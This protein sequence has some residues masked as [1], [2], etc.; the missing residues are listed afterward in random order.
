MKYSAVTPIVLP[1]RKWPNRTITHSP[2]WCSVDLRDGNQA[3][4]NP[5]G[6][7][8]KLQLFKLLV[9]IG[10]KEIEIGFPA[11]SDT[12][13]N[14]CRLLIDEDHIPDDVTVQVLT[15]ARPELITRTFDALKGAKSSIV[16]FYNST[17]PAQRKIVFNAT[18]TEVC[19][20]AKQAARLIKA[21]SQSN[22]QTKWVYQYSPES[23]SLTEL[24]FAKRIC[25]EVIDIL[26]KDIII[27]LPATV[28]STTPNIYADQ[29]EWMVDQLDVRT[30]SLH[31]HN[32]RGCGVAAT[33]LGILA[34]ASRVEGTLFGNGERTGNADI[35]T[36]ALNLF[37]Q[38][39][40]P[41]LDFSN[42]PKIADTYT[43]LTGMS[44]H[45]RHP[46][47]G[48]LVF[49]AFS[50]SHQDAIAKGMAAQDPNGKWE[51]PYLPIDPKDIGIGYEPIVR[52]NSQSG[53]GGAK[54]VLESQLGINLPRV[55]SVDV[56][57]MTKTLSDR[58]QREIT[59]DE[60]MAGF[61]SEF[62][63]PD[64]SIQIVESQTNAKTNVELSIKLSIDGTESEHK[65]SGNGPI[66]A[67]CKILSDITKQNI[68]VDGYQE[69]SMGE[70]AN[71]KAFA[72]VYRLGKCG[73]GIDTNSEQ[74]ALKAVIALTNRT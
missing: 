74:A 16:H 60:L 30:I 12:E 13:Y 14:F 24:P 19:D 29:I 34:G 50:G 58:L 1:Q 26:G 49:T 59:Q 55:L 51:V 53:K 15:Q 6:I 40:A 63:Q 25:Q 4:P 71:A 22:P 33:E 39:V 61:Y 56:G 65:A 3:L 8:Q 10:F 52:I 47:A 69:F 48:E 9:E 18:K 41:H 11:A 38:G 23:F 28:E 2:I 45:E 35:I 20:I 7:K 36:L 46:Y 54:F 72:V 66:N 5:M 67:L 62:T 17:N 44:I 27:N 21:L 32:D 57:I 37:S 70:G 64:G 68:E 43:K 73:V 31:T 42:L